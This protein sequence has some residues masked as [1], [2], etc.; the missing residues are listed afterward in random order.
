MNIIFVAML[1][2]LVPLSVAQQTTQEVKHAP[3]IEQCR[4]DQKASGANLGQRNGHGA[5]D[6]TDPT[7]SAWSTEM[8]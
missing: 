2:L 5:D 4:A 1:A 7:L 8:Y 6:V 3:T